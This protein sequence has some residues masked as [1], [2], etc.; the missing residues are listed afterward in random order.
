MAKKT[1]KK[2]NPVILVLICA[3]L[4]FA[5]YLSLSTIALGLWGQTVMGTVDSYDAR[6]DDSHADANRSRT[7]SKS[8]Y[9]TVDGKEYRG[10]VM[11]TSDE[12]WPRLADGET[13]TERIS[14][15]AFFPHINKPSALAEFS[16]MEEMAIIYHILSPVACF[17]LLLLVTGTLK[18]KEKK[19]R[20]TPTSAYSQKSRLQPGGAVV[21]SNCGYQLAENVSFCANCGTSVR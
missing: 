8:Y 9:F 3:C 1:N 14:Y 21:C 13:R 17:F 18:K 10:H 19:K 16:R 7:I 2:I 11:Y 15:F 6:L 5:M 4:L 20:A 12:S